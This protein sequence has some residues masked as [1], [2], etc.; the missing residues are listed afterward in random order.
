MPT[1][2][3][4]MYA[5]QATGS[6]HYFSV[7][8]SYGNTCQSPASELS[9]LQLHLKDT[10]CIVTN[11][12]GIQSLIVTYSKQSEPF[13]KAFCNLA[14]HILHLANSASDNYFS[15]KTLKRFLK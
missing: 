8:M 2:R 14:Q 9:A 11:L 15:E 4:S 13:P 12:S 10:V 1:I 7:S 6:K 3:C 5:D